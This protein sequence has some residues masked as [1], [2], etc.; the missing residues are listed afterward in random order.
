M[1]TLDTIPHPHLRISIMYMNEK[2]LLKVETGPYEQIYKFTREM[3]ADID[4]VKK[5]VTPEFLEEVTAVFNKMHE[6]FLKRF[7]R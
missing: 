2:Y 6:N 5:I 1:R 4:Q 3:A 7:S